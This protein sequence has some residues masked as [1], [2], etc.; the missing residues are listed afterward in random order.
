[1][2]FGQFPV[3]V[4]GG[5]DLGTGVVLRL[6][7]AGFPVVV[8]ELDRPLAVR[9]RAAVA[10][11]VLDGETTV[12]GMHAVRHRDAESARSCAASGTVAVLVHDGLPDVGAQIVIDARIAKRN[13]GTRISDAPFVVGLGPGFSAG[14]DCHAV[15]ETARGPHLGRVIY[16]GA[17]TPDTGVPDPVEGRASDRVLRAPGDGRV[18]WL[19]DIGA[20]VRAGQPIGSVVGHPASA[21][22]SL[23]ASFDGVVRGLISEA[24]PVTAGL[25]IGDIDPRPDTSVDEV[26]DKALAI[27]GGVLEAVLTWISA[28]S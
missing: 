11:A 3:L 15:V 17:A 18:S 1:M 4:R 28:G 25:K 2:L 26:S 22:L 16:R 10:T 12:E 14:V 27:G 19:V 23:T 8:T 24:T 5:G 6:H 20:I 7:R 21:P 13:L 9:R